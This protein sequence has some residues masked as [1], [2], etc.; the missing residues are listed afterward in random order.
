M[1]RNP[2]WAWSVRV[3]KRHGVAAACIALQDSAG[4]DINLLLFCLWAGKSR[5]ALAVTTMKTAL[6]VSLEWRS[7]VIE[8]LRNVRRH[9]KEPAQSSPGLRALRD[10]VLALELEAERMQQD[11][12]Y[13]LVG[14]TKPGKGEAAL[15]AADNLAAYCRLAGIRLR[16]AD[17][18]ALKIVVRTAL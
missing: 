10:R 16:P 9:L 3:Y 4:V 15:M 18:T 13:A 2:F 12:L 11:A 14:K 5:I 17:W 7:H 1:A 8:P 6:A